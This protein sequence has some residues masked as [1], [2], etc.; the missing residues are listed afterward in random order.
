MVAFTVDQAYLKE[1][2]LFGLP[3]VPFEQVEALYPPTAYKMAI[4]LGFRDLNGFREKKYS[5]AKAKGYELITHVSSKAITWPDL[6]IGENSVIS[7]GVI[8]QP[9]VRIGNDVMIAAGAS[10]GHHSSIQDHCFIASRAVVLGNVTVEPFCVLG[11]NCTLKDGITVRRECII[12]SGSYI[13][14]DTKE[15]GVYVNKPA[16]LIS[17][18]S[19]EMKR[20]L[21][22]AED[23][24]RDRSN[25]S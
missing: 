21:T 19:H 24:R 16:E 17:K 15:K 4:F 3:V 1:E 23:L 12:G 5:Q 25:R 11:A 14:E 7:E 13:S 8:V 22:W 9:R 10:V 20:L 6:T 18:S 2:T